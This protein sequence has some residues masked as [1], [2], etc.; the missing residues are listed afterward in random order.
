MVYK[1][2]DLF[3]NISEIDTN[4]I[5]EERDVKEEKKLQRLL[6]NNEENN[7]SVGHVRHRLQR[8]STEHRTE[9]LQRL[10]LLRHR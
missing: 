3:S 1:Q 8:R 4:K 9:N 10:R 7:L 2:F 6:Y 5:R